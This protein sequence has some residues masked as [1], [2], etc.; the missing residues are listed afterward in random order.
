MS[1]AYKTQGISKYPSLQRKASTF[2]CLLSFVLSYLYVLSVRVSQY[3]R[4]SSYLDREIV[5]VLR[6]L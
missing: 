3:V 6:R 1:N 5:N 2:S 4:T